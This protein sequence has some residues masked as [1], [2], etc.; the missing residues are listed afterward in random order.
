[1]TSRNSNIKTNEDYKEWL[2]ALENLNVSE[3]KE[4]TETLLSNLLSEA[5][6]LGLILMIPHFSR[7]RI[8]YLEI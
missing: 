8:L 4:F 1:M 3:G 7:L 6:A 2:E 5:K